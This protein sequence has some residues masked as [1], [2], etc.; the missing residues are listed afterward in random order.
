[1]IQSLAFFESGHHHHHHQHLM[2]GGGGGKVG[3]HHHHNMA[4]QPSAV[5]TGQQQQ[6][7]HGGGGK[8]LTSSG[9]LSTSQQHPVSQHESDESLCQDQ[10]SIGTGQTSS[11]KTNQGV[12][13]SSSSSSTS[14]KQ[15][16]HRTRFTPAQLNELERSFTKTH[17]PDIFM[18]EEIAMR[19]GLTESRV[20]VNIVDN[21]FFSLKSAVR[22]SCRP[23]DQ[24]QSEKGQSLES[25]LMASSSPTVCPSF[26]LSVRPSFSVGKIYRKKKGK[27][28]PIKHYES[29]RVLLLL[30]LLLVFSCQRRDR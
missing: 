21:T 27:R 2:G 20:Q 14:V 13:S 30:L 26:H 22:F 10:T 11:H 9:F 12:G 7:Q 24:Q 8:H 25:F 28:R 19:I 3:H 15:K 1:M 4:V 23:F 29:E 6:Q 18:R 5:Q 17:Y 16:R